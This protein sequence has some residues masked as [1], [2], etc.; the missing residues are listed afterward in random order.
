MSGSALFDFGISLLLLAG[1]VVLFFYAIDRLAP[2]PFFNKIAR[3]A[4][5][6]AAFVLFLFA[7][8]AVLFGGGGALVISPLG[9]FKFAIG[10]LVAVCVLVL[11]E[12]AAK[13]FVP[14]FVTTIMVIANAV[15]LIALLALA[16]DVL[17]GGNFM[18]GGRLL[19]G[20]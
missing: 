16:A 3:F 1:V 13:Y 12:M 4:V 15:V 19:Q 11:I 9:I 2:D 6:I 18:A 10:I 17:A 7:V 5:G 20:R 8:K 14:N